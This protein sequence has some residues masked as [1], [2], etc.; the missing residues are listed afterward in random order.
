M[1]ELQNITA[2]LLDI[3][4]LWGV[5][6]NNTPVY[7]LKPFREIGQSFEVS[8]R[9][10]KLVKNLEIFR[11]NNEIIIEFGFRITLRIM[12]I[13]EAIIHLGQ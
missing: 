7:I 13:S 6:S 12:L 1:Q 10:G 5:S 8:L 9:G 11:M 2:L 3:F 4:F